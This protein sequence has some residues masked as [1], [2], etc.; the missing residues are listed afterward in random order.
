MKKLNPFFLIG[1][2]GMFLTAVLHIVIAFL[3][4]GREVL[5]AS[6]ILYPVFLILLLNGT[7]IMIIRKNRQAPQEN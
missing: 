5:A 7:R 4:S 3:S 1:T 6:S 2:V